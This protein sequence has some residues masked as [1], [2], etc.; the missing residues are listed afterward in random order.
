MEK[1][2]KH[3]TLPLILVEKNIPVEINP[4]FQSF[5]GYKL[6]RLNKIFDNKLFFYD[7]RNPVE[8][9]DLLKD[10]GAAVVYIKKSNGHFHRVL[11]TIA[12]INHK[13]P[14][15]LLTL[16]DLKTVKS[17]PHPELDLHAL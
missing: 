4:A 14:G 11:L 2:Y 8:I 5:T 13:H 6:P 9:Q 17:G 12:K 10:S 3:L 1:E 7:H 15:R 16:T